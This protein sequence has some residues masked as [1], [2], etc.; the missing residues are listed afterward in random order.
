MG[1]RGL[2]F[3]NS[4]CNNKPPISP[5]IINATSSRTEQGRPSDYKLH[6]N[7]HINRT[8]NELPLIN[9]KQASKRNDDPKGPIR[10][11]H[12]NI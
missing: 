1:E 2:K 3:A 12:Q 5:N 4:N 7:Y 8:N 11:Y 10:I 6:F 9:E